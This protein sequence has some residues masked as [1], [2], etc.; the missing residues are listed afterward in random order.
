MA[1][2]YIYKQTRMRRIIQ[3]TQSEKNQQKIGIYRLEINK[4]LIF[5]TKYKITKLLLAR[6]QEWL[7]KQGKLQWTFLHFLFHLIDPIT[8]DLESTSHSKSSWARYIYQGKRLETARIAELKGRQGIWTWN[9]ALLFPTHAL[10]TSPL[11]CAEFL[12]QPRPARLSGRALRVASR[13]CRAQSW[14]PGNCK[15]AEEARALRVGAL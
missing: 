6:S 15:Q 12:P 5:I 14:N 10:L 1:K 11:P 8:L 3:S 4:L 9:L 13:N 7:K 2:P